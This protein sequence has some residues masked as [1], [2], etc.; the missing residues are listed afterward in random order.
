MDRSHVSKRP[1]T[2]M[3]TSSTPASGTAIHDGTPKYEAPSSMPMNS[4]AIVKKLST[5]RSP[6]A[7]RPQTLPKRSKMRRPWPTPET[8]PRRTTI[9]WLT[10]STGMSNSSV[11]SNVGP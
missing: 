9:S 3:P 8:A 6:T 5:K 1:L 7:K 11:Q 2:V 10:M 4:V